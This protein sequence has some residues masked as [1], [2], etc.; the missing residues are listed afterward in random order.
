MLVVEKLKVCFPGFDL[1]ASFTVHSHERMALVGRSGLGKSTLLRLIAGFEPV[2]SGRVFLNG[3]DLTR[4]PVSKREIGFVF[5]E[6]ALFSGRSISENIGFGLK[7]RGLSRAE[8]ER[9][10][11]PWLER[12]G[13]KHRD[14]EQVDHLSGGEKQRVA[15]ARAL[16][17]EPRLILLDEPLTGLD[18]QLRETLLRDIIDYHESHPVPLLFVSHDSGD[19][20]GLGTGALHFAELSEGSLRR[21]ERV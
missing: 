5:Q 13:L 17:I 4:V 3:Q 8:Q 15:L 9:K 21:V 14:R 11:A 19:Q 18:T 10:I 1:E 12:I 7:I 16:V 6:Q 2:A 20:I